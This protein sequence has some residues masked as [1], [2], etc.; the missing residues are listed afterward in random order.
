MIGRDNHTGIQLDNFSVSR[1]KDGK[2]DGS[3]GSV[4]ISYWRN[5]THFV[6][7]FRGSLLLTMRIN[8]PYNLDFFSIGLT[9]S[10]QVVLY[11]PNDFKLLQRH[12]WALKLGLKQ[13]LD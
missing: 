1:N 9:D 3:S 7:N 4:G 2:G 13:P 6:D 8:E 11:P 12:P 5:P 10:F